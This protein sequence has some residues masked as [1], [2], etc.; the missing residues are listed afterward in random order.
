MTQKDQKSYSTTGKKLAPHFNNSNAGETIVF[1]GFISTLYI[2]QSL[3]LKNANVM[4]P[5]SR[6]DRFVFPY[7]TAESRT[8][9]SLLLQYPSHSVNLRFSLVTQSEFNNHFLSTNKIN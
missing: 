3:L 2:S 5:T 9:T 8:T 7:I 6:G 1:G 4:S